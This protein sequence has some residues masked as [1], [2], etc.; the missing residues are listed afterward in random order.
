MNCSPD[1]SHLDQ[2][3]GNKHGS[4]DPQS[5]LPVHQ[6]VHIATFT[7][8]IVTRITS[9]ATPTTKPLLSRQYSHIVSPLCRHPHAT[10]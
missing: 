9:I 8:I 7:T 6:T 2:A 1:D 3:L 10:V 4:P 5:R